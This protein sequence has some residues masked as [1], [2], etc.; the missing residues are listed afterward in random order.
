MRKLGVIVV[1]KQIRQRVGCWGVGVDMGMWIDQADRS[2][3]FVDG[4]ANGVSHGWNFG[5]E[6]GE[7]GTHIGTSYSSQDTDFW[8]PAGYPVLPVSRAMEVQQWGGGSQT[9]GL[10]MFCDVKMDRVKGFLLEFMPF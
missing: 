2:N 10:G 7:D 1:P 9:C 5:H 8:H 4:V 3:R 6:S